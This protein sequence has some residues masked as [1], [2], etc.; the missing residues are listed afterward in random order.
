MH[1]DDEW[2]LGLFENVA[3]GDGILQVLV[4]VEISLLEHFH[5][6]GFI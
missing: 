5:S 6:I 4:S 2:M 3:L 1:L